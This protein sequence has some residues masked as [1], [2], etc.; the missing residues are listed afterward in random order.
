MNS[1]SEISNNYVAIGEGKARLS[2][3]KTILLSILAGMFIAIAGVGAT[4]GSCMVENPSIS[5]LISGCIF[6]GGLA[7]VILAGSE[8]FTGDCLMVISV[9]EKKIKVIEML[10]TWVL[11]YLGNFIGGLIISA[12]VVYGHTFS[13][14]N[15]GLAE[16]AV[17]IAAGKCNLSFQ[18]AFIRGIMCNIL[19]CIAVWMGFAAK[20]AGGKVIAIFLP[21]MIF[22]IC[23]YEHSVANM[24]Y[25]P[26][27]LFAAS[28]YGIQAEGLTWANF[29]IKNEIPVTLGN[30][31]GGGLVGTLYWAIYIKKNNK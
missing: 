21:I 15:N 10:R 23:G 29:L 4:A 3:S 14:F 8:L 26:S 24:C 17:K 2:T 1:P 22:V 9:Y 13:L 20:D 11:V 7:M 19:V 12:F 6:P 30:I 27:G 28:E 31:V 16:S 25:V 5:K 18:D